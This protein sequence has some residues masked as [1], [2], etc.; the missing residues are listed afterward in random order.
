MI[1]TKGVLI[2]NAIAP[3][4]SRVLLF[5]STSYSKNNV[6]SPQYTKNKD[7][8]SHDNKNNHYNIHGTLDNTLLAKLLGLLVAGGAIYFVSPKKHTSKKQNTQLHDT[9]EN[10][11]ESD[12]STKETNSA[13]NSS[14]SAENIEVNNSEGLKDLE[15]VNGESFSDTEKEVNKEGAYNPDTGEINWDCPCLGGMAHGPCGEEFKEA[16]ACFVYSEADPKG[17]DCVEKFQKMQDCFRKYPEHYA[18]QLKDEEEINKQ[19]EN[20]IEQN[21]SGSNNIATEEFVEVDTPET[22]KN[23]NSESLPDITEEEAV[24]VKD[25]PHNG[26]LNHDEVAKEITDTMEEVELTENN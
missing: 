7:Q 4:T 8:S 25:V 19:L 3:V 5:H 12:N 17:I 13:V 26:N 11:N 14:L 23:A 21:D 10:I 1:Q 20:E 16:F 24:I 18:E 15:T 22:T 9:I 6:V 2:K